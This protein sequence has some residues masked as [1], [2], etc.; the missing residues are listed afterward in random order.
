MT[1]VYTEVWTTGMDTVDGPATGYVVPPVVIVV[2]LGQYV[3]YTEEISV[4]I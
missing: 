2:A 1:E 4:V 3:V